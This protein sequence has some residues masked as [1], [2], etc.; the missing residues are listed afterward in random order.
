MARTAT[1]PTIVHIGILR[2][3]RPTPV[4]DWVRATCIAAKFTIATAPTQGMVHVIAT[5]PHS[6]AV[7]MRAATTFAAAKKGAR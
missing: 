5:D 3:E 2:P 4:T 7:M 6:A 1:S